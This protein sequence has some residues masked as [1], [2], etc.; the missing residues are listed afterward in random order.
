MIQ[1]FF[2]VVSTKRQVI[3]I[4]R[5]LMIITTSFMILFQ[6]G[7]AILTLELAGLILLFVVSN[8]VLTFLPKRMYTGP[9]IYCM[10]VLVDTMIIVFCHYRI[11]P[12]SIDFYLVYFMIMLIAASGAELKWIILNTITLCVA[13]TVLLFS[14][15]SIHDLTD[16]SIYLRIPL[17]FIVSLLYSYLAQRTKNIR[18]ENVQLKSTIRT[19]QAMS[20]TMDIMGIVHVMIQG[21]NEGVGSISVRILDVDTEKR[22]SEILISPELIEEGESIGEPINEKIQELMKDKIAPIEGDRLLDG[23]FHDVS[24]EEE[25][26]DRLLIPL[27]TL[28]DS[29]HLAVYLVKRSGHIS[30]RENEF[31]REIVWTTITVLHNA[32]LLKKSKVEAVVDSMT[33]LYNHRHFQHCLRQETERFARHDRHFSLLILDIDNFKMINDSYGHQVGDE[34]IKFMADILSE[35]VRTNDIIAR[36]GGD[37][38]AVILPETPENDAFQMAQRICERARVSIGIQGVDLTISL[39]IG[40]A[41]CPKHATE[42]KKLLLLADQ[43]L[44]M[45]KYQGKNRCRM[46]SKGDGSWDEESLKALFSVTVARNIEQ[47]EDGSSELIHKLDDFL[48]MDMG[49]NT[50]VEMLSSLSRAINAKDGYT[51]RHSSEVAVIAVTLAH[52]MDLPRDEIEKIRV[53]GLLHDIGKIGVSAGI[54]NKEE[55]LD[56][57]EWEQIRQHPSIGEQILRPIQAFKDI[58]R[59]VRHHHEAW[60]GS[61]YPDGL[62][63]EDIPLGAQ[64]ISIADVYHAMITDRPY[65]KGMELEKARGIIRDEAGHKWHPKLVDLFLKLIEGKST[66]ALLTSSSQV[67]VEREEVKDVA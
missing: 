47:S 51:E 29:G 14:R 8:L 21:L 27:M 53:A 56:E 9:A 48:L 3:L 6:N 66:E 33:G 10:I 64:I 16:V 41:T 60:D 52:A 20:S 37:E 65:R 35:E 31:I 59:I 32:T 40:V 34:V 61:G 24:G 22:T 26:I 7:N 12:K 17:L 44:Y 43:A 63:G 5:W 62:K 49:S 55:E 57:E 4:L 45:A 39:S 30:K 1:D 28:A 54:L 15:M 38:F 18:S 19:L 67:L 58:L 25:T 46:A 23:E 36:Y 42:A 13:Y 2:R 11:G 50:T